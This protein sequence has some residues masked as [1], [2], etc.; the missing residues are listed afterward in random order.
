VFFLKRTME[1]VAGVRHARKAGEPTPAR[2][3]RDPTDV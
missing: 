1:L 3:L 2:L